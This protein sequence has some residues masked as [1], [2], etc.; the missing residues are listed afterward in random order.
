MGI[1]LYTKDFNLD[2]EAKKHKDAADALW[3]VREEYKSLITDFDVLSNE[4]IRSKRDMLIQM[5]AGVNEKYPGT[6]DKSFKEAQKE[7][8]DEERQTFHPGEAEKFL[9]PKNKQR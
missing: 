4:E 8:K 7:L 6:D 2:S 9:P 5:V 1:T 3:R